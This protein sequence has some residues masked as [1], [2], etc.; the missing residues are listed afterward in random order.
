MPLRDTLSFFDKLRPIPISPAI[1]A[2][3]G[4]VGGTWDCS[5]GYRRRLIEHLLPTGA[6]AGDRGNTSIGRLKNKALHPRRSVA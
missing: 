6:V 1:E 3:D 2:D 4:L 5:H